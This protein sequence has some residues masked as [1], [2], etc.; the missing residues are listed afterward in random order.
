VIL[1]NVAGET[2]PYEEFFHE[3]IM[4]KKRDHSYRVFKKVNRM[5]A[6]FPGAYEYSWGERPITVWCSNDYLGMSC[7]PEVKEAV[8]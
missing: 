4:Q 7:H 1:T 6:E 3:Q 5:A 8:R 2:F